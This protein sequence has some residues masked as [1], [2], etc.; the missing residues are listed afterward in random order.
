MRGRRR[1]RRVLAISTLALP[2]GTLWTYC[3]LAE[4]DRADCGPVL[5][6]LYYTSGIGLLMVVLGAIGVCV[7]GVGLLVTRLRRDRY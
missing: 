6:A 3:G 5:N 7:S 1:L 2:V 4:C